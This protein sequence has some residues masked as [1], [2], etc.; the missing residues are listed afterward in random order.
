MRRAL[1]SSDLASQLDVYRLSILT[2]YRLTGKRAASEALPDH[3]AH[4]LALHTNVHSQVRV[5][6]PSRPVIGITLP[7]ASACR[8]WKA[9]R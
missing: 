2:E 5:R 7:L 1:T 3:T 6:S 9:P 4:R 8:Q